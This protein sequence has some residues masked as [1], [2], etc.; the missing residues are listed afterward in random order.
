MNAFVR[1]R[2]ANS[3][4]SFRLSYVFVGLLLF[5]VADTASVHAQALPSL[6][7]GFRNIFSKKAPPTLPPDDPSIPPLGDPLRAAYDVQFQSGTAFGGWRT[8]RITSGPN[9]TG[10]TLAGSPDTA[11]GPTTLILPSGGG[12]QLASVAM[13]RPLVVFAVSYSLGSEIPP[14]IIRA[15][16]QP[17]ASGFYLAQPANAFEPPNSTTNNDTF[18]WSPHAQ[19]VYATQP[20]VVTILWR[21]RVSGNL[22]SQQYVISNSP[23]K[24]ERKIYWTENGFNGPKVQVP[25]S[26]V[27]AVNIVY[28]SLMPRTVAT[29]FVSPY[30]TP[31]A[32]GSQI[33]PELRTLWYDPLTSLIQAYNREGRVF[34]EYLGNVKP[35]GVDREQLGYEI[36]SVIKETRP[37]TLKVDIGD[38]VEPPPDVADGK[39]GLNPDPDLKSVII[40]GAGTSA[41]N[42][43][44]YQ[45]VSQGGAKQTLYAIRETAAGVFINGTEEQVG[46]EVL[47]YWEEAGERGILWPK[48]Y[49]GYILKWP[50]DQGR[51]STYARSDQSLGDASATG[52]QLFSGNN[53]ALVYQDDPTNQHA[54]LGPGNVFY[55]NVTAGSPDGR[56]LIRY[57]NGDQIWFERVF[58]QLDTTFANFGSPVVAEIG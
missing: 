48:Y 38:T 23:A 15:D 56:S 4:R 37:A 9:G 24:A 35:G 17:A 2:C 39:G 58:S 8:T 3:R 29:A 41:G 51:Y 19:K 53:P 10:F 46:N 6:E 47:I 28:N 30:I 12:V 26:R 54:V 13:A 7:S 40:A 5:F 27:S 45:H 34:V 1:S 32:P 43:Y 31:P 57:T 11:P 44:L 18:Y 21:E 49:T 52:V 36:V 25:T 22:F 42:Q 55:T 14:P 50:A 20:G 33:P 16:G